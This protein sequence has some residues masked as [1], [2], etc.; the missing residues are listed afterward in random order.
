MRR[1]QDQPRAPLSG[2]GLTDSDNVAHVFR[3]KPTA[4]L[5]E[6]AFH[7]PNERDRAAEAGHRK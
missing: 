1:T 4:S 5:H 3:T 2:H 6:V 7:Q